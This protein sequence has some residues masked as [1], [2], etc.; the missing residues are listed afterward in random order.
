MPTE[1]GS[2]AVNTS[3]HHLSVFDATAGVPVL[4]GEVF[5]G[6]EPVSVRE[7]TSGEVWV[8]SHISDAVNIVD[9]STM[10]VVRTLLPGDEPT[11]VVFAGNRAFVCLSQEDR[12]AVYDTSDL[13]LDPTFIDLDMSDPR[14]LV[15]SGDGSRVYVCALD[16]QNET[17]IVPREAVDALGGPPAPDP[18]MDG[19]LPAAPEV[20]L[21]VRHDGAAWRDETGGAWSSAIP[22]TLLDQ[23]VIG[24]DTASLAVV[25][26]FR[27]AGT[28]LFNLAVNPATGVIYCTNQEALNEVRFEPKLKANF[29]RNRI[30]VID[31]I[32][33]GVSPIPLN[34]HIDFDDPN[35]SPFERAESLAFPLDVVVSED[36]SRVYVAAFGSAKVGVLDAGG[37]GFARSPS[38]T[39][40][41]D[42]PSTTT[43]TGSSFSTGSRRQ[44]PWCR[45]STTRP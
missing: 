38:A 6:M 35:G 31:P 21:I 37:R 44:S 25:D 23:D 42:W 9:V 2:I 30:T 40:R 33:G 18:P 32:G 22:Y 16:S 10:R 29:I 24:I 28:A 45:C 13:D 20:G 14:S 8:V 5:V 39:G 15:V 3:E 4:L 41:A 12:I 26:I 43:G 17:T 19:D 27:G 36:G 1:I 11:D 7:R 34:P